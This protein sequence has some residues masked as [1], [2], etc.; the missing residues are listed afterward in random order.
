MW[1]VFIQ[2]LYNQMHVI[3]E[4]KTLSISDLICLALD[5]CIV[6]TYLQGKGMQHALHFPSSFLLIIRRVCF[7]FIIIF[8]NK[9]VH[10]P[11]R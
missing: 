3:K 9:Q 6:S 8:E 1:L 2:L 7:H 10:I 5:I 11:N 4:V